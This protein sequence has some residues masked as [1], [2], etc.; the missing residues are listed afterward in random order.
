MN[1]MKDFKKIADDVMKEINISDELKEKTL[2]RCM[3]KSYTHINKLLISAACIVLILGV[4]FI[5]DI[6]PL[7]TRP[8][9]NDYS[10]ISPM[11]TDDIPQILLGP[12][13]DTTLLK[14]WM[15]NT[16]DETKKQFGDFFLVPSYVPND[17]ILDEI[18][19]SGKQEEEQAKT[20]TSIVLTFVSSEK[21]FQIIQEKSSF[22]NE[23]IGY[24]PVD[25]NGVNGYLIRGASDIDESLDGV[26]TELHW[27]LNDVHYSVS[28]QITENEGIE[29]RHLN[30]Y[31]K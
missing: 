15:L 31:K 25:I 8:D 30:K 26:I 20:A 19:A 5:K 7:K 29:V 24:K 16:Q 1:D 22:Q 14:T 9:P 4:A 21:S 17:F 10:D 23:F 28:G 2:K 13:D 6:I 27:F 18:Y 12:S 3:K 11:G